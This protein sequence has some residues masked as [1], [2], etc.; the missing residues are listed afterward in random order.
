MILDCFRVF[1]CEITIFYYE[2][3]HGIPPRH[4]C[5]SKSK[6]FLALCRW[7]QLEIRALG[8]LPQVLQNFRRWHGYENSFNSCQSEIV[9]CSYRL[10][11]TF[12]SL[13]DDFSK[14]TLTGKA[15]SYPSGVQLPPGLLWCYGSSELKLLSP[16]NSLSSTNIL[17]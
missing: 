17:M 8:L 3:A 6:W 2:L 4:M 7:R 5:P 11:L 14:P 10:T 16:N 13:K 15:N 1:Y 12:V 9:L